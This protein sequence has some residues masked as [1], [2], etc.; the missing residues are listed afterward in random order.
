MPEVIRLKN[1][2]FPL[3]YLYNND[4]CWPIIKIFRNYE[5]KKFVEI[6]TKK[7]K[8]DKPQHLLYS[9]RKLQHGIV[10]I[11]QIILSLIFSDFPE[12][13]DL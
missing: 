9:F 7:F 10:I 12:F 5:K 3:T 6:E 8:T 13:S 11:V 4:Q 2:Y 1:N